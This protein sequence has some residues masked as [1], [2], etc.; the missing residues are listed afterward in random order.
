MA[1]T[2]NVQ[3]LAGHV[4]TAPAGSDLEKRCIAYER[5][6]HLDALILTLQECPQCIEDHREKLRHELNMELEW[7][8]PDDEMYLENVRSLQEELVKLG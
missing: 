7:G 2:Y 3:C 5:R 4:G 1:G 8:D 6:G